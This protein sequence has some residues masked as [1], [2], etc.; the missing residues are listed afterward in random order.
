MFASGLTQGSNEIEAAAYRFQIFWQDIL[1]FTHQH[2][3]DH[4]QKKI[5][6]SGQK[7]CNLCLHR[8]WYSAEDVLSEK[9]T[10]ISNMMVSA[11][12]I[13]DTSQMTSYIESVTERFS[14]T[15]RKIP[16][17]VDGS[18]SSLYSSTGVDYRESEN[19]LKMADDSRLADEFKLFR[20]IM[21]KSRPA[22]EGSGVHSAFA[23]GT[24]YDGYLEEWYTGI[25]LAQGS[26]Y[27]MA[28]N[29]PQKFSQWLK[30]NP[31][32][33]KNWEYNE[34]K[35]TWKA[36]KKE[37]PVSQSPDV[38]EGVDSW[39]EFLNDKYDSWLKSHNK[40]TSDY[41]RASN[42][43][44]FRDW[45][46]LEELVKQYI[47]YV[48]D[49]SPEGWTNGVD[50]GSLNKILDQYADT[51][52]AKNLRDSEIDSKTG[53]P[54]DL[55]NTE[56]WD[57]FVRKQGSIE[58]AEKLGF[59]HL[60]ANM[61][62]EDLPESWQER[63]GLSGQ[64]DIESAIKML[65]SAYDDD[66]ADNIF[67]KIFNLTKSLPGEEIA[68][69][70]GQTRGWFGN[71]ISEHLTKIADVLGVTYTEGG[72][73]GYQRYAASWEGGDWDKLDLDLLKR[74]VTVMNGAG[75]S[76]EESAEILAKTI[77]DEWK[78]QRLSELQGGEYDTWKLAN[79][80][81][82]QSS[83]DESAKLLVSLL[84]G[85]TDSFSASQTGGY[86]SNGLSQTFSG[87]IDNSTFSSPTMFGFSQ[88]FAGASGS[89]STYKNPYEFF[90]GRDQ[91]GNDLYMPQEMADAMRSKNENWIETDPTSAVLAQHKQRMS[92]WGYDRSSMGLPASSNKWADKIPTTSGGDSTS[93]S[94]GAIQV[95]QT[96]NL[97]L[98]GYNGSIQELVSTLAQ[99][100][101]I[102]AQKALLE[103]VEF[104]GV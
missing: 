80:A 5:H 57:A 82:T 35:G 99:E 96:F 39:D 97:D 13:S 73:V 87:G 100:A 70:G 79:S 7:T 76:E 36:L 68:F 65:D 84:S 89:S 62:I 17:T 91:Y 90:H 10:K 64:W 12:D 59:G 56:W 33:R 55:V 3:W 92:D 53:L 6:S 54:V 72:G 14:D 44:E 46:N 23:G 81:W 42:V 101:A 16:T 19:I 24:D 4:Y 86:W 88:T 93:L 75:A 78:K 43:S 95:N 77:A 63:L 32:Q 51:D 67:G 30:E 2:R 41:A 34:G 60:P 26:V 25:G 85:M 58:S 11:F 38:A 66:S 50:R 103:L 47:D 15:F 52:L 74:L 71:D 9:L 28:E 29:D 102:E 37:I 83:E 40:G 48:K 69:S 98:G 22:N 1:S 104:R 61:G 49:A 18:I 31:N 21:T 45:N 27:S 94:V 8:V 20:D